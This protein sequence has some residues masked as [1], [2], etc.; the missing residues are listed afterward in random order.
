MR[1][2]AKA[3]ERFE[4]TGVDPINAEPVHIYGIHRPAGA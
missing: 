2:A 4:R 1:G 3:G